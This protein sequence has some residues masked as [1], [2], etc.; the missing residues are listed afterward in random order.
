LTLGLYRRPS[1]SSLDGTWF[2]SWRSFCAGRCG[3]ASALWCCGR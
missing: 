1:L 2:S 3:L